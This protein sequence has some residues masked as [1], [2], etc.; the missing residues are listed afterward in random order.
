MLW[1]C[2]CLFFL[3]L[4]ETIR[5]YKRWQRKVYYFFFK[6][7][8]LSP[9]ISLLTTFSIALFKNIWNYKKVNR[10]CIKRQYKDE[11]EDARLSLKYEAIKRCVCECYTKRI[12]FKSFSETSYEKTSLSFIQFHINKLNFFDSHIFPNFQGKLFS[13]NLLWSTNLWRPWRTD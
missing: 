4:Q 10:K 5:K 12:N 13:Q 8:L 11:K 9:N 1:K 6:F 3:T 2:F 7:K